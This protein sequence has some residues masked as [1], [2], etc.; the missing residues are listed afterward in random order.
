MEL[1]ARYEILGELIAEALAIVDIAEYLGCIHVISHAL[2]V[3]LA[4]KGQIL[5]RAIHKNPKAWC[6]LGVRIRSFSIVKESL[7]H[8]AGL[9]SS[10]NDA[11]K[12]MDSK[13]RELCEYKAKV[14]EGYKDLIR[15][16]LVT[17]EP[18]YLEHQS[19]VSQE[20]GIGIYAK[21]VI[22]WMA[23]AYYYRWI[24]IMMA[25][26]RD[27]QADD[28]GWR[29]YNSIWHGPKFWMSESDT[30]RFLAKHSMTTRS[31]K[32][33]AETIKFIKTGVQKIVNPLLASR[34]SLDL[35]R[36]DAPRSHFVCTIINENEVVRLWE[37]D[38]LDWTQPANAPSIPRVMST[39]TDSTRKLESLKRPRAETDPPES[40]EMAKKRRTEENV[41]VDEPY[42]QPVIYAYPPPIPP[43]VEP[44]AAAEPAQ[45]SATA[46][47]TTKP[48]PTANKKP[49]TVTSA[50]SKP[51]VTVT[52]P[53]V[54]V[55]KKTKAAPAA[56]KGKES[57]DT[58]PKVG[59]KPKAA[60]STESS[61]STKVGPK[62]KAA[63][64]VKKAKDSTE[65]TDKVIKKPKPAV[66]KKKTGQSSESAEKPIEKLKVAAPKEKTGQSS[67][68]TQKTTK[69]AKAA[70]PVETAMASSGTT[71]KAVTKPKA[72]RPAKKPKRLQ[73]VLTRS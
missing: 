12:D 47:S 2:D 71:P 70:A 11:E 38:E 55:V 20:N 5:W 63:A 62:P 30:E 51:K 33:F 58:F 35:S 45:D 72:A 73:R 24:G 65:G 39:L 49:E 27:H 31:R 3:Q 6:E 14:L 48:T 18:E 61:E 42:K 44:E 22:D 21:Q 8:L 53:K 59:P 50:K 25:K 13:I 36:L 4:E 60:P 16:R 52:V 40:S 34:L 41:V 19:E 26:R 46:E 23:L 28:G 17:Y 66:S 32:N 10:F 54:K 1:S 7:V 69:K 56:K 15:W 57:S 67:K 43:V 9:W 64:T 29:L 68:D 37:V